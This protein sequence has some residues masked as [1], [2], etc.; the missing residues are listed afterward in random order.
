MKEENRMNKKY[1][2]DGIEIKALQPTIHGHLIELQQLYNSMEGEVD[3][4]LNRM[5][6]NYYRDEIDK[7]VKLYPELSITF[8]LKNYGF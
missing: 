4:N 8:H 7:T 5:K 6:A 3:T 1:I 2:S